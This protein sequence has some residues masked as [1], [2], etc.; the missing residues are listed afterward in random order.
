MDAKKFFSTALLIV[1]LIVT[2]VSMFIVG[3]ANP[4][5]LLNTIQEFEGQYEPNESLTEAE[6]VDACRNMGVT[7]TA[8][9][10]R[11][12]VRPIFNYTMRNDIP[13]SFDDVAKNGGDCYDWSL[14]Y[15]AMAEQLNFTT[16]TRTY[17][18]ISGIVPGHQWMIMYNDTNYCE[19]DQM[20]I[21]KCGVRR[22]AA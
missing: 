8:Y 13:K 5:V 16:A 1:T 12:N 17:R 18:G 19:I 22:D 21:K 11:D 15:V 2:N 9:C 14:M 3:S 10:L 20:T 4:D 6:I 7:E